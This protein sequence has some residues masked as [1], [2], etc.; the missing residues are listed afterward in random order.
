[1]TED[2]IEKLLEAARWESSAGNVQPWA[3]VVASSQ[4]MKQSLFMAA[5]GQKDLEGASVVFVV[6]AEETVAEQ[7]Y[8]VRGKSL[9][10]V[11]DPAATIQNILLTPYSLG[12]GSCWIG[13]F[14]E[15]EIRQVIKAPKEMRPKALIPI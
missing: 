10:C 11:Q 2:I 9:Y 1:M 3:F 4:K 15:D 13:A 12:L 14:K 7:G 5:F 8:G 6:C